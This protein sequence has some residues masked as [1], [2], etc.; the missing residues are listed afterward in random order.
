MYTI[1]TYLFNYVFYCKVDFK[2]KQNCLLKILYET[3]NIL[4]VDEI[5]QFANTLKKNMFITTIYY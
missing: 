4:E 2:W 3:I 1:T 5:Y